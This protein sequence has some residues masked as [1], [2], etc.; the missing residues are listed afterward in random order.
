MLIYPSETRVSV[1]RLSNVWTPT[2]VDDI[3]SD[4]AVIERNSSDNKSA[5]AMDLDFISYHSYVLAEIE[6]S[7]LNWFASDA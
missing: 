2:L 5:T 1:S 3:P 6:V 7:A 4:D